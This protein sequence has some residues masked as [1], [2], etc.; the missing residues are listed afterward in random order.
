MRM[1]KNKE[2]ETPELQSPSPEYP[3]F[4]DSP[5]EDFFNDEDDSEIEEENPCLRA[6]RQKIT[7]KKYV[8]NGFHRHLSNDFLDSKV[9]DSFKRE[10]EIINE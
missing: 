10:E 2:P 8:G 3:P 9:L 4:M 7:Q 6:P 1:F 5:K